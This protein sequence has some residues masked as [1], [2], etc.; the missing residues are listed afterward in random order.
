MSKSFKSF[1]VIESS[2]QIIRNESGQA[3]HKEFKGRYVPPKL[4]PSD[5][6]PFQTDTKEKKYWIQWVLLLVVIMCIVSFW[7]LQR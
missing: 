6:T 5:E 1:A 7:Y 3:M 4:S 2:R